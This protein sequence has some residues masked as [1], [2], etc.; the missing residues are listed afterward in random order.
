MV[1][2]PCSRVYFIPFYE[3]LLFHSLSHQFLRWWYLTE[4]CEKSQKQHQG[5]MWLFLWVLFPFISG[6]PLLQPQN[7]WL[8]K[9]RMGLGFSQGGKESACN[10]GAARDVGLIP[11]SEDSLE[12]G[13]E[14]HSGIL[15]WRI[16]WTEEPSRLKSLGSQRVRH[17]WVT[18]TF[19]L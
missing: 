11:G 5:H 12:E 9:L 6:L 7:M 17:D 14:T 13:M 4:S 3:L 10:A 2:F 19:F 15:A 18:F 1:N 16:S 8:Q